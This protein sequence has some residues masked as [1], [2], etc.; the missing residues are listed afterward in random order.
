MS[1]HQL[2]PFRFITLDGV[3]DPSSQSIELIVR[4]GVDGVAALRTG[5]RGVP[6]RAISRVDVDTKADAQELLDAYKAVKESDPLELIWSDHARG[7]VLVLDVR[8]LDLREILGGTGG[9]SANSGGWLECEW[10][11]V[12]L[13]PA[14]LLA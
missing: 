14:M 3:P 8:P 7:R 6:F 5:K 10:D 9:L 1:L 4:P 11:L 2:G 13:N 12:L